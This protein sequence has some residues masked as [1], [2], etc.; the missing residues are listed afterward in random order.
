MIIPPEKRCLKVNIDSENTLKFRVYFLAT[1]KFLYLTISS[2]WERTSFLFSCFQCV[3]KYIYIVHKNF[4]LGS[5]YG[6]ELEASGKFSV[7][8]FQSAP[9]LFSS[10]SCSWNN[11]PNE[12]YNNRFIR[13]KYSEAFGNSWN[14]KV[15]LW[16][17]TGCQLMP[18]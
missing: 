1:Y 13:F 18:L 12:I 6:T 5:P 15:N 4:K 3:C 7:L 11:Y 8:M 17:K 2:C 14:A 9:V 10:V 16:R